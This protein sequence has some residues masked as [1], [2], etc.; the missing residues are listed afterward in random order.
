V[1]QRTYLQATAQA[2]RDA[3][4]ADPRVFVMGEDVQSGIYGD[5]GHREFG[6]ERV[7]N[8]P[9][10][11]AA[12][13]GAGIGAALTG[14]RPVIEATASTF[15]YMAMDQIV[16][17]AAKIRYMTGGQ[18]R[19]PLV[20]RSTVLYAVG[21]A[22][23]HSDRAWAMFAQC[24]GLRIVV[25][26]TPYDAKGLMTAAI[27]DDNPVLWFDDT[28][29]WGRRGDVPDEDYVVPLGKADIKRAGTDLTIVALAGA[30]QQSLLAAQQLE[31]ERIS[32]EVIDLRTVAP[33]DRETVLESVA[34]TG[35]LLA[36]DLA[37]GTCS[38]ASEIAATV[39][40]QAFDRLRAPVKRLT[41]PDVPVPFSPAL[42]QLMYPTAQR[43]VEAARIVCG[44]HSKQTQ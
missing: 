13:F 44:Y 42:E 23:H 30:V 21:G 1:P 9:I 17:Q 3:M 41:A 43:I 7:R 11:E 18:A 37:P 8:T 14:M 27:R 34:K 29:L 35:R 4:R 24:P 15:L 5:Y 28:N 38:V 33:L 19:V 39:A 25:P 22:A 40:E 12:F 6:T 20:I 2:V 16:N 10:S 32:V 36:V 31:A 26:S